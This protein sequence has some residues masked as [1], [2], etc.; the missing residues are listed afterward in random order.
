PAIRKRRREKSSPKAW[1]RVSMSSRPWVGCAR[2][3]A[4]ALTR[5][6]PGLAAAASSSIAPSPEWRTMK[7]RTSI[8][9]MFFRVSQA[10]SP[11]VVEEVAASK[12]S[13]SAP[14][15]WLA[16][17]KLSRVRV[18][19]SKNR[20]HTAVPARAWRAS[21]PPAKA[22][23]RSSRAT[24]ACRGRPSSVS[25]WRSRPSESV[26]SVMGG[27]CPANPPRGGGQTVGAPSGAIPLAGTPG[28]E[29][30]APEGAPTYLQGR[31]VLRGGEPA[32]DDH[33]RRHRIERRR[34]APPAAALGPVQ[35]EP[36]R[37]LDRTGALV[38]HR[39]RQPVAALEFARARA[40][41]GAARLAPTLRGH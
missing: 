28:R 32:L 7:P 10:V 21:A 14:R 41:A 1:R 33:R 19:G 34:V 12:P 23:A 30:I 8:A 11:L 22:W 2:R 5:A 29:G 26:C 4:P 6:V 13:T 38:D 27:Y 9:S 18:D 16:R 20:V 40:G 24:R 17:W 37:G 31:G 39:Y 15:R 25:R 35:R 36:L 3:P